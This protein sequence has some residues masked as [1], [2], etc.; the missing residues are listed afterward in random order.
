M[1]CQL[2][3]FEE[4]HS[5]ECSLYQECTCPFDQDT[6]REIGH[7]LDCPRKDEKT[8]WAEERIKNLPPKLL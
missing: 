4:G 2:C 3:Q 1:N 7:R 6:A 5:F 8:W